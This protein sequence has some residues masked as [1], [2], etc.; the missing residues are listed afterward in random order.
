MHRVRIV[1][2]EALRDVLGRVLK[3]CGSHRKAAQALR[4]GQTTFTRL[5]N[6]TTHQ[7]MSFET[8]WSIKEALGDHSIEFALIDQF[9][10]SVFTMEGWLV[11]QEYEIWVEKEFERLRSKV[12][13]VLH[14]LW[15]HPDYRPLFEAFLEHVTHRPWLPRLQDKRHWVALYRAVEPFGDARSTWGVERTWEEMHR[16][17]DLQGATDLRRYLKHALLRERLILDRK[18]DLERCRKL[19][20]PDEFLAELAEDYEPSP[21]EVAEERAR[22]WDPLREKRERE[23]TKSD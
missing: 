14:E 20:T 18:P 13:K 22:V 10:G 15:D 1:D 11:W 5:L 12:E 21:E 7:A 16:A 9:E 8:Y 2:G 19:E 3:K 6:G 4:I 23:K 17:R